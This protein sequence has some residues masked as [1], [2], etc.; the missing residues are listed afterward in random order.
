MLLY[1][2]HLFDF[3]LPYFQDIQKDYC[4]DLSIGFFFLCCYVYPAMFSRNPEPK[5]FRKGLKNSIPKSHRILLYDGCNGSR[6]MTNQV[7]ES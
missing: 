7:I 1:F 5:S 6:T 3:Y 2:T 4:S